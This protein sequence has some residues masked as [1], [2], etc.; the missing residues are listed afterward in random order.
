MIRQSALVAL[1]IALTGCAATDESTATP[2][3]TTQPPV[4]TTRPAVITPAPQPTTAPATVPIPPGCQPAPADVVAT[5]SA[6]FSDPSNTLAD[7]YVVTAP[8]GLAYIGA[9]I[10]QGTTKVSSADVW[11][12]RGGSVYSLSGDARRRTTLPDGRKV[13]SASAGDDYGTKV[14]GCVTTAERARNQSG[15][16]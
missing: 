5:I 13:L 1:A 16:R 7:T 3:T 8:G 11:V 9:N 4:T 15:G 6:A 2:T 12:T 10:M 14:Q